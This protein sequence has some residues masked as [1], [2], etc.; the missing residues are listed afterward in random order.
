MTASISSI[1][2]GAVAESQARYRAEPQFAVSILK[3]IVMNLATIGIYQYYW[4]YKQWVAIREREGG[5]VSPGARAVFGR[6]FAFDLFPRIRATA[7]AN[8]IDVQWGGTALAFLYL[9][10]TAMWRLPEPYDLL[11]LF[12]FTPLIFVQATINKMNAELAPAAPKND[13]FSAWNI[14]GMVLGV[15]LLSLIVIGVMMPEK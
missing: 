7:Q 3:L 4:H 15:I 12:S 9:L 1:A 5:S 14:A 8:R 11:G 10:A 6:L 13:G 2:P